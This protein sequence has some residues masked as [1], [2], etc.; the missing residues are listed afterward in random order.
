[1]FNF[2]QNKLIDIDGFFLMGGET[3]D[4]RITQ[5]HTYVDN[6]SKLYEKPASDLH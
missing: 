6:A 5:E 4:K 3:F 2:P 1:M